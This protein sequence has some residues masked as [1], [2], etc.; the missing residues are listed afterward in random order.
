MQADLIT[1]IAELKLTDIFIVSMNHDDCKHI[2]R[3]GFSAGGK[4]ILQRAKRASTRCTGAGIAVEAGGADV[5]QGTL[6]DLSVSESFEIGI[7]EQGG[8]DLNQLSLGRLMFLEPMNDF[9]HSAPLPKTDALGTDVDGFV[10]HLCHAAVENSDDDQKD[11][12][13]RQ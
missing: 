13:D 7:E 1:H 10:Q 11:R 9:L 12:R 8:I 2:V 5:F 3:C 6:V 4:R